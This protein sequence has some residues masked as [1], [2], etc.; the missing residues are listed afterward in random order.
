MPTL[1]GKKGFTLIEAM[2]ASAIIGIVAAGIYQLAINGFAM[3]NKGTARIELD[4]EMRL[5]LSVIKKAVQ[6]SQGSTI[7]ISRLSDNAPANS[8]FSAILGE[9]LYITSNRVKCGRGISADPEVIGLEGVPIEIYQDRN[10]IVMSVAAV[11]P[12][13]DMTN[14]ASIKA[15]TYYNVLTI[16]SNAELLSFAFRDSRESG[17]IAAAVKLSKWAMNNEPPI[18]LFRREIATIKRMHSA[19]VYNE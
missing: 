3:W 6:L 11:R 18:S 10:Y 19:G 7:S 16:T 4:N 15:N 2:I 13:T 12:G 8:Y 1:R 14:A 5:A 9:T 17:Q